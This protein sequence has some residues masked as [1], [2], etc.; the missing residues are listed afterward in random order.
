[1]EDKDVKYCDTVKEII[2]NSVNMFPNDIAF[3]VKIKN[4]DKN[5]PA[6]YEDHTFTD[7]L[8]DV[9]AVGSSLYAHGLQGKRV[10]II[11]RNQYNW[12]VTHLSCLFGGIV[13]VPIDKELPL[14]EMEDSLARAEADAV[15][16]D[17]KYK[18][19][20]S[21]IKAN[22]KTNLKE[23]F[24]M[25]EEL[26]GFTSIKTLLAEGKKIVESG[27][28]TFI[29]FKPDGS[30]MAILLFTSGTTSK[31]KAVMLSGKGIATNV[32]DLLIHEKFE[33]NSTNIAFLPFH[34]IF[35]STCM[36]YTIA[37]GM[38]TVF[39]DGLR[40]IKQNFEEYQVSFF[41]G[42]PALIDNMYTGLEKEIERQGKTKSVEF[43]KKLCRFLLFFH[44]DIRRKVFKSVIDQMG[45]RMH[46]IISG[47]APL[48]KRVA[49]GFADYGIYI[50]QGYGLTETSPVLAAENY[51]HVKAGSIGVPM[52]SVKA[53]FHDK[54]DDGIGELCVQA[55]NVMMGYYKNPELTNEIIYDGWFH[56][57]D[58]GYMDEE[59]YIHL[60]GRKKDM[61]VLKNGKKV[62]P[63]ELE[64]LVKKIPGVMDA[65]IYGEPK[66]GDFSDLLI[67]L[68]I[69][70]NKKE[71]AKIYGD[72][73]TEELTQKI[74]EQVKEVNKTVPSYKYI[75]EIYLTEDAFVKTT[76]M[77]TKRKEELAMV[78]KRKGISK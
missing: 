58:L 49:A 42:V 15:V 6:V 29:D 74:W 12:V 11:G 24:C 64:L 21:T 68:E 38:K 18:D 26:E 72:I 7:F 43:A 78:F 75:K 48:S 22:G 20:I 46:Y 57:G 32:C 60:T 14:G 28:R 25:N 51:N 45:G 2:I 36:L 35:G 5:S 62:F 76:S 66:N 4:K 70:Y 59:G 1:M 50:Y 3:R 13:S 31:S 40:Y 63:E 17:Y 44:I 30:K 8:N 10:A 54:D 69:Q 34:H 53:E 61:I 27:D 37:Y 9:Y 39:P 71:A 52:P 65:F 19:A 55:P 73:S 33:P 56:T 77:K 67:A 23:F 47:G 41:V 16:F